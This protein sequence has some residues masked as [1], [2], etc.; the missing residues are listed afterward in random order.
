MLDDIRFNNAAD[1]AAI[2]AAAGYVF[3]PFSDAC[4]ARI[5]P[6]GNVVGGFLYSAYTGV[7]GSIYIHV[8]GFKREWG[9]RK[10]LWLAFDYPFSQLMVRKIFVQTRADNREA[11]KLARHIGFSDEHCIRDVYADGDMMVLAM[12]RDDCR[13]LDGQRLLKGLKDGR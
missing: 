4:I 2:G 11:L 9:T 6:K 12:Y 8:A 1:A 7:G 5:T 10:L 3:N 13:F